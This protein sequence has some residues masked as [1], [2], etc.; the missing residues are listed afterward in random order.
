MGQLDQFAK[1]TF[2]LEAASVTHGGVS[3][4]LPPELGM[5]EVRLDGLL[6]VHDPS[7]LTTLAPPW[8]LVEQADEVALEVK[9]QGDHSDLLS[10]DRASLR[11]LARQVQRREDPG[12]RFDG[13]SS[14]WYVA[15][16]VPAIIKKRRPVTLV[17]PGCYRIGP[18]WFSTSGSQRTTCR[19]WTS[20]SRS[21]SPGPGNR[22]MRSSG[23]SRHAG[24]YP[25]CC[26]C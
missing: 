6:R 26:V 12:E 14:L 22:S 10:F 4:Q 15:S 3:W 17:A 18:D 25:G 16:H 20:W 1:D 2:A 7:L 11:R 13:E 19:W 8:S 9:M 5:S 21:W 23:G 24:R